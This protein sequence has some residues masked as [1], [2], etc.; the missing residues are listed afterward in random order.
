MKSINQLQFYPEINEATIKIDSSAPLFLKEYI[1]EKAPKKSLL[2]K[3]KNKLRKL[4]PT[5]WFDGV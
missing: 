4:Q 1:Q 2:L 3:A 5:H